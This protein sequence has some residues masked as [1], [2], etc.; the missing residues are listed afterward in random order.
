MKRFKPFLTERGL[1]SNAE[2]L[3][4]SPILT[5]YVQGVVYAMLG[6]TGCARDAVV[7][8]WEYLER[9]QHGGHPYPMLAIRE[10]VKVLAATYERLH[11]DRHDAVMRAQREEAVRRRP[12]LG[13]W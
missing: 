9:P 8:P 13:I 6:G 2:A 4:E 5:G 1:E 7:D 3:A 10:A 12:N 11:V